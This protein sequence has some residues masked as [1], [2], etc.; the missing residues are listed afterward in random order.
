MK[1]HKAIFEELMVLEEFQVK[2]VLGLMKAVLVIKNIASGE[3]ISKENLTSD[4]I[5][6][7]KIN[8][9]ELVRSE[10]KKQKINLID[11]EADEN[12]YSKKTKSQK[13]SKKAT[14]AITLELWQAKNSLEDIA[15]LRKFSRQTIIS[16]IVKLIETGDISI[17]EILPEDKIKE[18]EKAF[19]NYHELALNPLKEKYGDQFTWDELK[20]FKAFIQSGK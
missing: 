14:T 20:M 17:H 3:T 2:S 11:D 10:F 15:I 9:L 8:K 7:Y 19:E 1:K 12:R 13:E 5:K 18:L 4:T 16:H 6:N